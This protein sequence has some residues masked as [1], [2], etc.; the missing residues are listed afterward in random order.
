M[1]EKFA[2]LF[3]DEDGM[4]MLGGTPRSQY[5]DIWGQTS[6][7]LREDEFDLLVER[8]AALEML[9]A[10]H[11][12]YDSLDKTVKSYCINNLDKMDEL[13]NS[14]YMELAGQLIYRVA[15]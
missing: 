13:K 6:K 8:I 15:D 3:D 7:D 5:W 14:V 4:G 2:A 11:H 9:L 1:K 12:D 10:E